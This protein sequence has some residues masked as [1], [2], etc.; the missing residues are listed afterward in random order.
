MNGNHDSGG[1]WL[2]CRLAESSCIRGLESVRVRSFPSKLR[3]G[4]DLT[5]DSRGSDDKGTAV[6]KMEIRELS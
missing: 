2:I 5:G 4:T 6:S 1:A 3:G